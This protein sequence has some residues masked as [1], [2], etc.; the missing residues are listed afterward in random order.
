MLQRGDDVPHFDV[1]T[2]GGDVFG[3]GTIWQ[4]RNLVL[5]VL[6]GSDADDGYIA[7]L[8]ARAAEFRDRETACV[9]TLD[10]VAGLPAPAILVADRWGEVVHVAT[11][12]DVSGLPTVQELLE[13]VD[14]V[15]QR[16]PECEGEA[17]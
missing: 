5:I 10:A 16:C 14:Y 2:V 9:I 4:R 3:Y 12:S 8:A 7:A 13:W 15:A 17:K 6:P 11:A 1:R